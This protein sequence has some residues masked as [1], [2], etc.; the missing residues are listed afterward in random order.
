MVEELTSGLVMRTPEPCSAKETSPS[1][2]VAAMDFISDSILSL[3]KP[4]DASPSITSLYLEEEE[5]EGGKAV[6]AKDEHHD[7]NKSG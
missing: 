7:S 6:G 1:S 3:S 2:R 5:R 4:T